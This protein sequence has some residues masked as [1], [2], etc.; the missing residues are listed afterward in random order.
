LLNMPRKTLPNGISR[1][2]LGDPLTDQ[3]MPGL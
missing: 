1:D 2:I 3:L